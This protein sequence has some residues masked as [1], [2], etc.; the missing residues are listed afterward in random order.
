MNKFVQQLDNAPYRVLEF[1][2][3]KT[4]SDL[5]KAF[6]RIMKEIVDQEKTTRHYKYFKELTFFL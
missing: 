1:V 4:M 3:N 6:K 2:E 5:L